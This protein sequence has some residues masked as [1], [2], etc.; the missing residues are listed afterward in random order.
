MIKYNKELKF[1]ILFISKYWKC[2]CVHLQ[3]KRGKKKEKI[4]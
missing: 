3:K 1:F 4:W 2:V